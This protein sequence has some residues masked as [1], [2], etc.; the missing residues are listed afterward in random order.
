M[1]FSFDEEDQVQNLHAHIAERVGV[2]VHQFVLLFQGRTLKASLKLMDTVARRGSTV[3]MQGVLKGSMMGQGLMGEWDCLQCG[4]K[5]GMS[6]PVLDLSG[7]IAL[8][9]NHISLY[10]SQHQNQFAQNSHGNVIRPTRRTSPTCVFNLCPG[11]LVR[12]AS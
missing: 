1:L 8:V 9:L 6:S 2:S 11:V 7:Y 10:E 5:K 12:V 3:Y 4:A